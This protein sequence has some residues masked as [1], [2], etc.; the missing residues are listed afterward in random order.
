MWHVPFDGL[1]WPASVVVFPTLRGGFPHDSIAYRSS[2]NYIQLQFPHH[3]F[4]WPNLLI[5]TL[6]VQT[7]VR[8]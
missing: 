7:W 3:R 2:S 6:A 8:E 4:E 1:F 5:G